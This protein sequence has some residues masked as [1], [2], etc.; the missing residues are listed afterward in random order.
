VSYI[1]RVAERALKTKPTRLLL[2]LLAFPFYL[3]GALLGLLLVVVLFAWGAL[4]TGIDDVRQ[5]A[6]S[7]KATGDSRGPD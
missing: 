1:D 5:Q 2:S 6:V 3:I 4:Q 7:M